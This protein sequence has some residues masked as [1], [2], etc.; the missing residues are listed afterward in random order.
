MIWKSLI[1]WTGLLVLAIL[2]GGFRIKLLN[3]Y[4]GETT[5]HITSTILLSLLILGFTCLVI[6][7]LRPATVPESLAIGLGWTLL[8]LGFEF[9][10]GHFLF[11]KTWSDLLADYNIAALR[12]WPLALI[13]T[14][15]SPWLAARIRNVI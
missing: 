11:G 12:I 2:N 1:L 3:P 7:W 9:G 15:L 8:T 5:G 14:F 10:A 6:R 13:T 4:L